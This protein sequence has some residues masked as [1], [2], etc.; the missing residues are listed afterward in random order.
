MNRTKSFYATVTASVTI[1]LILGL[2][3][4]NSAGLLSHWT[5]DETTGSTAA[6]SVGGNDGALQ[7]GMT[8][9]AD[10]N[11]FGTVPGKFGGALRGF[12]ATEYVDVGNVLNPGTSDYSFT[13]WFKA[14]SQRSGF[15]FSKGNGVTSYPAWSAIYSS[16]KWDARAS[17]NDIPGEGTAERKRFRTNVA[18]SLD[19][20]YHVA[21]VFDKDPATPDPDCCDGND[22][23]NEWNFTAYL[24]GN[25]FPVKNI[26]EEM[27]GAITINDSI[28]FGRRVGT[29]FVGSA[30]HADGTIDDVGIFDVALTQTQVQNIMANG[31]PEP[32]TIVIVLMGLAGSA[33][34]FRRYRRSK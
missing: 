1:V 17:A 16:S 20:W 13:G 3:N 4:N 23:T 26:N 32:S 9:D 19:T 27:S 29:G 22:A 25:P 6:D 31:V 30:H 12:S 8:F 15:V 24:D 10:P 7:G 11:G 2:T 14:A 5:F 33:L 21:L 18:N 34:V 28:H